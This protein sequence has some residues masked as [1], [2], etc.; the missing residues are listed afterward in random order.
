MLC[1]QEF[2]YHP[3]GFDYDFDADLG[4][5]TFMAGFFISSYEECK[6]TTKLVIRDFAP[7]RKKRSLA[8]PVRGNLYHYFLQKYLAR[9]ADPQLVKKFFYRIRGVDYDFDP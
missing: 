6:L 5:Y 2:F 3:Q 8:H 7:T 1:Y 4:V 9:C